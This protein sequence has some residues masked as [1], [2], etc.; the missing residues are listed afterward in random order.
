[1]VAPV[2]G[3]V[4]IK[5]PGAT[6]FKPLDRGVRARIGSTLDTRKGT[7][8]LV[9]AR[10]RTGGSQKGTFWGAVFQVRQTRR[11]RGLTDLVLRAG[12]FAACRSGAAKARASVLAR[13]SGGTS[14]VVR[15]LWGKDRHG[16]FRT[17]GRDSVATVRGTVWSTADRC[18]GTMTT[19]KQGKV[20]VRNRHSGRT[21][22]LTAGR[23]YLAR[24][25]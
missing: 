15:R 22:L 21:V 14:R 8:E 6:L 24:R 1:M 11:S 7:V 17:H 16:R 3:T 18:D 20:S 13:D 12:N 9:S 25:R 2:S 4:L 10:N 23:S 5:P 19:V